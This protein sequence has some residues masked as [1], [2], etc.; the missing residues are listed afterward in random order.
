MTLE[1]RIENTKVFAHAW[2]DKKVKCLVST[3]GTTLEGTPHKKKR[4]RINNGRS[5]TFYKEVKRQKMSEDYFEGASV[6]DVD[7]HLRQYG[8]AL[9]QSWS[10][11]SWSHR[12]FSTLLGISECDA[13]LSY[14]RFE[15]KT[16][17]HAEFTE[18]LSL[19][20]ISN[21]FDGAFYCLL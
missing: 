5:E 10:T 4:W 11:K 16:M 8:L 1:A 7:N 2:Y 9:E 12:V 21:K 18:L 17:K 13:F 15:E 6:I 14:C 3:C 20:L 19:Q